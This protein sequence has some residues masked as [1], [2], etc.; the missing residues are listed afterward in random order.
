MIEC[1]SW[2]CLLRCMYTLLGYEFFIWI[3]R[4]FSRSPQWG[5]RT[6]SVIFFST[7]LVLFGL[8]FVRFFFNQEHLVERKDG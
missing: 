3:R 6:F 8:G 4:F 2:V 7:Y 5:H 1:C